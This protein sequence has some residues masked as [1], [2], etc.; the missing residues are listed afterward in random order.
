MCGQWSDPTGSPFRK[1]GCAV[2][3]AGRWH[4]HL[5][6]TARRWAVIRRTAPALLAASALLLPLG[7]GPADAVTGTPSSAAPTVRWVTVSLGV[8]RYGHLRR[9]GSLVA[10]AGPTGVGFT[11]GVEGASV[12]PNSFQVTADGSVW[13]LDSVNSRALVWPPGR[14]AGPPRVVRLPSAGT[15][16]F[17]VATDGTL[18]VASIVN[19][20]LLLF[21]YAPDGRLRWRAPL[22]TFVLGDQL[23]LAPGGVLYDAVA[24]SSKWVPLTTPAGM[25]LT[26][27][28]RGAGT[29]PWQ[30]VT[31]GR[32]LAWTSTSAHEFRFTLRG[33]DGALLHGWRLTSSTPLGGLVDPPALVGKDLVVALRAGEPASSPS[34]PEN[35]VVRVSPAGTL[36]ASFSLDGGA[37][38]GDVVTS[39]RVGPDGA[40]YALRTDPA[41]GASIDRFELSGGRHHG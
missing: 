36:V 6:M 14:P 13:L 27:A 28:Q 21:A 29:R 5:W 3:G 4:L 38:W 37:V 23:R 41:T 17:A 33:P 15:A 39:T 30:P 31:G 16:D 19:G 34:R 10:T 35:Q 2:M 18:Y 40:L 26:P 9:P 7:A 22:P 1:R 11:S 8:H 24:G 20:P 25:P 12:G 32:R